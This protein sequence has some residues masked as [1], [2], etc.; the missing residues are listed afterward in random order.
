MAQST[1]AGLPIVSNDK[2]FIFNDTPLLVEQIN[3]ENGYGKDCIPYSPQEY[4]LY[5]NRYL[6]PIGPQQQVKKPDL[7]N[8]PESSGKKYKTKK[9]IKAKNNNKKQDYQR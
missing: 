5:I 2:H 6:K 3:M 7:E 8:T 9:H 1:V 4:L